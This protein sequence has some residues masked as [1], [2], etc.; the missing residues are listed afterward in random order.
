MIKIRGDFIQS[1][2]GS[3]HNMQSIRSLYVGGDETIGFRI[4]MSFEYP[5]SKTRNMGYWSL[6][7]THKTK[8]EAQAQLDGIFDLIEYERYG[9]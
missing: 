2:D 7:E 8:D 5:D 4:C 3:W 6:G 1:S 9:D